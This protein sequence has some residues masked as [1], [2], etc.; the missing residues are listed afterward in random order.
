MEQQLNYTEYILS[1]A[2]ILFVFYYTNQTKP[3][4]SR[5]MHHKICS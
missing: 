4:R 1:K 2:I 5:I 3:S